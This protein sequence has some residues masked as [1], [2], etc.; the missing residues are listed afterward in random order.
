MRRS[1]RIGGQLWLAVAGWLILGSVLR[2]DVHFTVGPTGQY[3]TVQEAVDAVPV[4]NTARH[5]INIQPGTYNARVKIPSTKPFITLRGE[6]PLTTILTFNETAA[7]LPNES[8]VHAT[9]VLQGADFVAENITFGNHAGRTAG[10][11]LAIYIKAA[12]PVGKTRSAARTAGIC[13][14][15]AMSRGASISSTAKGRRILRTPPSSPRRA[16]TSPRRGAKRRP[17]PTATFSR[18]L[19]SPARAAWRTAA[20]TWAGRGRRIRGACSSIAR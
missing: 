11:A 18:T 15:T 14:T 19:P 12:S 13:S 20:C 3:A 10:Q 17:R 7:T 2:A 1:R 9:T 8:T 5:V 4:N 16:A 6:D